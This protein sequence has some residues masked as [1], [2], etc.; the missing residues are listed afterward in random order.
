M[1]RLLKSYLFILAFFS[2]ASTYSQS[3]LIFAPPSFYSQGKKAVPVDLIDVKLDIK[4]DAKTEK[5]V[6]TAILSFTTSEDGFHFQQ[7]GHQD[8]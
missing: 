4:V 3:D 8:F 1:I 2:C 5:V 6:S 7:R